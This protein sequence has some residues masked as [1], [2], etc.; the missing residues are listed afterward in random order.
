MKHTWARRSCVAD[1]AL[2]RVQQGGYMP[3][4]IEEAGDVAQWV[5]DKQ[6]LEVQLS[7]ELVDCFNKPDLIGP[8][9]A[10]AGR[11]LDEMIVSANAEAKVLG[12]LKE[13]VK[14]EKEGMKLLTRETFTTAPAPK[15]TK[16]SEPAGKKITDVKADDPVPGLVALH[17][18]VQSFDCQECSDVIRLYGEFVEGVGPIAKDLTEKFK[19]LYDQIDTK[20]KDVQKGGADVWNTEF[21]EGKEIINPKTKKKY[22]FGRHRV[23]AK[24]QYDELLKPEKALDLVSV[25]QFLGTM[26]GG[27]SIWSLKDTSTIN[28]MDQLF[29]LVPASDIS[30]TTTDTI[31]FLQ[32][33]LGANVMGKFDHVFYMLPLATIVAGAHHSTLEVAL[34]LAQSG[35]LN[36]RIGYYDTLMPVKRTSHPGVKLVDAVLKAAQKDPRNRQMLVFYSEP[37]KI[38]G[39]YQFTGNESSWLKFCEATSAMNL[40]QKSPVWPTKKDVYKLILENKLA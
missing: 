35:I 33:F 40:C 18:D 7:L 25:Q 16:K 13:K 4:L 34:P 24:G 11:A 20:K 29:G 31:F 32:R 28:K 6:A 12:A 39:C 1:S 21:R 22:D 10:A 23:N 30:G 5:Q 15:G 14:K 38:A 27:Q 36:Y 2:L 3:K 26:K 9:R 37:K 19:K 17:D 8:L